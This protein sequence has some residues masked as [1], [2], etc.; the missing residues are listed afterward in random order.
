MFKTQTFQISWFILSVLM[1]ISWGIGLYFYS[2]VNG[3]MVIYIDRYYWVHPYW[4]LLAGATFATLLTL[5]AAAY[6]G[7]A[8]QF[9]KPSKRGMTASFFTSAV[10]VVTIYLQVSVF[11]LNE[12]ICH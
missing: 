4:G 12:G 1:L 9:R 6:T 5:L 3:N 11:N 8:K 2:V 7:K 10:W